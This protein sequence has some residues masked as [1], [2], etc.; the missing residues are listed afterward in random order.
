MQVICHHRT[1]VSNSWRHVAIMW[2]FWQSWG[3]HGLCDAAGPWAACLTLCLRK[4]KRRFQKNNRYRVPYLPKTDKACFLYAEKNARKLIVLLR[5]LIA[6]PLPLS[7]HTHTHTHRH[8]KV[9]YM[10]EFLYYNLKLLVWS[11]CFN[12]NCKEGSLTVLLSILNTI[13]YILTWRDSVEFAISALGEM[14]LDQ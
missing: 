11:Y 10:L 14:T 7:L 3:G 13:Q 5:P 8:L 12:L 2:L 1:W 6:P 4:R 9:Q